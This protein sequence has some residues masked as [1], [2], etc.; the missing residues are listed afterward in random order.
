MSENFKSIV[1]YYEENIRE[2]I[3]RRDKYPKDSEVYGWIDDDIWKE[4]EALDL[5]LKDEESFSYFMD[6]LN[7]RG[8][9]WCLE[10]GKIKVLAC[11]FGHNNTYEYG[12]RPPEKYECTVD[13]YFLCDL[14]DYENFEPIACG[15]CCGCGDW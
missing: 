7:A 2:L 6:G 9:D 1:A 4:R 3:E 13:D 10:H 8:I 5:L 12:E 14:M 15:E 11:K